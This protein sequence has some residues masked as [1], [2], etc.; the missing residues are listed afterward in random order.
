[1]KHIWT[2]VLIT[3]FVLKSFAQVH[4][5]DQIDTT[6]VHTSITIKI[7]TVFSKELLE[8]AE[9]KDLEKTM[10]KI[11]QWYKENP[12]I[13]YDGLSQDQKDSIME[14]LEPK[15]AI[16]TKHLW[17]KVEPKMSALIRKFWYEVDSEWRQIE[18]LHLIKARSENS[19]SALSHK[20]KM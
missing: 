12:V 8:S 1:M 6:K 7:D 11:N 15:R 20:S 18:L 10:Y 2:A 3:F 5:R 14:I 16:M 13:F 19:I 17:D 4:P 9:F